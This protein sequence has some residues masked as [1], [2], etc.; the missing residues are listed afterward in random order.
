MCAGGRKSCDS[1]GVTY[2][3]L[4]VQRHDAG[5]VRADDGLACAHH[6]GRRL[7][8]ELVGDEEEQE[9][10]LEEVHAAARCGVSGFFFGHFT[11]TALSR[12]REIRER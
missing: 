10:S 8:L 1:H 3:V 6:A 9:A 2:L 7:D 12:D 4:G 5:L 11:D